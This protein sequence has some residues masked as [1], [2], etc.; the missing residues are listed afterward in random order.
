LCCYAGVAV[1]DGAKQ[2]KK[3]LQAGVK[4]LR[5][6]KKMVG[7]KADPMMASSLDAHSGYTKTI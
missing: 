3:A 6:T 7:M 2:G 5:T 4:A 1:Q